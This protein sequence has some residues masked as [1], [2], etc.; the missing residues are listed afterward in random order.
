MPVVAITRYLIYQP[1]ANVGLNRIKARIGNLEFYFITM[2]SC[3]HAAAHL[4]GITAHARSG[5]LD[6][7]RQVPAF[8]MNSVCNCQA[9]AQCY[10]SS[11]RYYLQEF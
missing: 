9:E 2:C 5:K 10:Y 11:T 7:G 4:A 1:V 6:A 8:R 3:S